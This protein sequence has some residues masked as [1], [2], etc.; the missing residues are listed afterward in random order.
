MM[1]RRGRGGR[2]R[3]RRGGVVD[4]SDEVDIMKATRMEGT[5][6]KG[7]RTEIEIFFQ[8]R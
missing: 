1:R 7:F 5:G 3:R 2:R 4:N 6:Y 8:D